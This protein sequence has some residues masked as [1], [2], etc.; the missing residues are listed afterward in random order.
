MWSSRRVGMLTA[1]VEGPHC[2]RLARAYHCGNQAVLREANLT[3]GTFVRRGH[4]VAGR[5][6]CRRRARV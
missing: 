6:P 2:G 5:R 1:V 4:V 3:K